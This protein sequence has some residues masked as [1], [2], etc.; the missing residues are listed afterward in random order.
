[1]LVLGNSSALE[2]YLT[3]LI[4]H[5]TMPTF[6]GTLP[7]DLE[8]ATI[9]SGG[10]LA[11]KHQWLQ[12]SVDEFRKARKPEETAPDAIWPESAELCEAEITTTT[13]ATGHTR[14]KRILM[15]GSGMVAAPAV[16]F[17]AQRS[18]VELIIG[19]SKNYSVVV[20]LNHVFSF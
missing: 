20:Q 14:K 4:G 17:I 3:N 16:D 19:I 18:D 2:P 6:D 7:P 12:P 15:F 1:L 9:A 5:I 8:R 13:T 10:V 11:D